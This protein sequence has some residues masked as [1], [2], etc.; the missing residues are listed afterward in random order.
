MYHYVRKIKEGR[1]PNIKGLEST[2][3]E[4][5]LQYL[6]ANYNIITMEQLLEAK[7]EDADLPERACLLTFDDGY[8][9][10]YTVAFP[11]LMKYKLQG[12]FFIP[13]RILEETYL[14][15]VNQLHYILA[16]GNIDDIVEVLMYSLDKLYEKQKIEKSA[17]ELYDSYAVQGRFDDPKT[18]FVKQMLQT[19]IKEEFRNTIVTELFDKF[20]D[21]S[22]EV[23]FDE[24][25]LTKEQ[26][27]VMK[28]A[29]MHIG[30]HAYNHQWL[31][32]LSYAEAEADL[33]KSVALLDEFIVKDRWVMNYPYGSYNDETIQIVEKLGGVVGFSTEVR[34]T[35]LA[36]DDIFALPRLDTNDYPPKSEK[37]KL[38]QN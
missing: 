15:G 10:H 38:Y 3:F 1:Y 24:L 25:Y 29:G 31:G 35:D 26:L 30:V 4:E 32:N 27:H 5:Q 17:Q 14:L 9:D 2:Q 6:K 36:C 19:I 23:L 22:T 11:L 33:Q 16:N 37:Y 7:Y 13:A 34:I 12:T 21:V 20:V 8:I 28:N 18:V